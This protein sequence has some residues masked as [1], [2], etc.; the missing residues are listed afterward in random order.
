[1]ANSHSSI[2]RQWAKKQK[3]LAGFDQQ[4][5][6]LFINQVD[7]PPPPRFFVRVAGKEFRW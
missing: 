6:V 1:M 5:E 7:I 2:R 3:L 4:K